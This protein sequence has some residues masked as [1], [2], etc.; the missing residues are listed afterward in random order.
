M[1]VVMNIQSGT[2]SA[3]VDTIVAIVNPISIES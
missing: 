3:D 1:R 2:L